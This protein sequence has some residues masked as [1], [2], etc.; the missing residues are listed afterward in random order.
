ME[1]N[2]AEAAAVTAVI[3]NEPAVV[4]V[5]VVVVVVASLASS[6]THRQGWGR[7]GEQLQGCPSKGAVAMLIVSTVIGALVVGNFFRT[8]V[9]VNSHDAHTGLN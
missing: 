9:I 7:V 8:M 6:G 4:T 5:T 3:L 1:E 2:V